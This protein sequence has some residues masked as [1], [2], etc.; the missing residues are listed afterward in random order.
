MSTFR[1]QNAN[2]REFFFFFN[3]HS[4]ASYDCSNKFLSTVS[5]CMAMIFFLNLVFIEATV[6][7]HL[8]FLFG[9]KALFLVLRS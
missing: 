1:A 6:R 4:R 2:L 9:D 5:M 3:A 8:F 7:L